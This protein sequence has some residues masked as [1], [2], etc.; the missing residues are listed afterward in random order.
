MPEDTKSKLQAALATLKVSLERN[1]EVTLALEGYFMFADSQT[2]AI[3]PAIQEF[4][5]QANEAIAIIQADPLFRDETKAGEKPL[6]SLYREVLLSHYLDVVNTLNN[7]AVETEPG[8]IF[9]HQ[10]K[11][12]ELARVSKPALKSVLYTL[13]SA[14]HFLGSVIL[15]TKIGVEVTLLMG[16]LA[17]VA[18]GAALIPITDK[19]KAQGR[20]L[21]EESSKHRYHASIVHNMNKKKEEMNKKRKKSSVS[22]DTKK[23]DRLEDIELHPIEKRTTK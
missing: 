19:L 6:N 5:N 20:H 22:R 18:F 10:N 1:T 11:L 16:P 2:V 12:Q 21:Y 8:K 17:G 14:L 23:S 13:A 3:A 15:T 9:S 7:A 4:K